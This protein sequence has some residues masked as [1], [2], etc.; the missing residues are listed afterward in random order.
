MY[1]DDLKEVNVQVDDVFLDPNNPRFWSEHS[2]KETVDKKIVEPKI[3]DLALERMKKYGIKELR[4]SILRNG[5]LPL[6]RIVV[7]PITGF[8]GKYVV[9]E[10]NRRLSALKLLRDQIEND[11]IDEEGI[12]EDYIERL[13]ENTKTLNVLVYEGSETHDIAWLLQGVRHIGGIRDWQPAQRAKLIADQI[14]GL[15][16]GYKQAGQQFGLTAQAVG[17]LYRA[18]KALEQMRSD[19][20]YQDLAKNEYFSLFEE[21]IRR[22][23]LKDWLGWS[24]SE[25]LFQNT[26]NLHQFYSWISPDPDHPETNRRIHD[27]KQIKHLAALV[28]ANSKNLLAKIDD[29]ELSIDAAFDRL[30][31]TPQSFDWAEALGKAEEILSSIPIS[32]LSEDSEEYISR[33][34]Q[35][36]TSLEKNIKM[37][38]A[39]QD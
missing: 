28:G 2:G 34:S 12:D 32:T 36:I 30:N 4:D 14:S 29:H 19:E 8:E 38:E 1:I 13:D 33:V 6:D 5:F 27:P 11:L 25:F 24:D 21:T 3:Q 39:V 26:D 20:E 16:L 17:R 18:Y 15:G 10:G 35:L 23:V 9:V 31:S 37:A 7:R 22:P